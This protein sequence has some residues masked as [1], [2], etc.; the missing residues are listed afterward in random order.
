MKVYIRVKSVGKRRDVL[1]KLPA[2]IPEDIDTAE[3][4][5]THLVIENVRAY[6]SKKIDAPFFKYLS[7]REIDDA[8][9]SGKIGFGDRKN[10]NFQDEAQAVANALQCFEDGIY[11]ILLNDSE[12]K[13][14]D[15]FVIRA[16]DCLTFVRLV[17]LAGRRW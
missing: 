3:K 7:N 14:D 11:R 1:E 17:M 15:R 12:I 16:D 9:F 4:L 10:E 13:P 2:E 6:N 5:I 8:A